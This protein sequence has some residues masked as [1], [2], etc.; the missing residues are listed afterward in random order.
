VT[1]VLA[2]RAALA[3]AARLLL[4][5]HLA[6]VL[7]EMT[8]AATGLDLPVLGAL[9]DAQARWRRPRASGFAEQVPRAYACRCAMCG[10]DGRLGRNPVA[11]GT[12]SR[13]MGLARHFRR[14][15]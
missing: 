11:I 4:D 14:R 12:A 2:D 7:S 8:C 9:Q 1:A 5:Q 13:F 15:M 10:F 3:A 6:P